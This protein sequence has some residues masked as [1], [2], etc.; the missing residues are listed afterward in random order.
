MSS[1]GDKRYK[2]LDHHIRRKI[3]QLLADESQTYSQLLTK[4][5]IESGHLAYHI[6]N[7]D[8]LLD[9][10]EEGNYYIS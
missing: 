6:R 5:K 3:I 10:D 9:K 7:L 8:E 1:L 4:L 2:A